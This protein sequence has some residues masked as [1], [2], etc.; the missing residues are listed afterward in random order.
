[1]NDI[2]TIKE[3]FLAIYD[4]IRHLT[5]DQLLHGPTETFTPHFK[6]LNALGAEEVDDE[7]A[8]KLRRDQELQTVIQ[9]ISHLKRLNG[10]RMEIEST[11]AIINS[12]DPWDELERFIYYPN[13]LELARME[14]NGAGLEPD[15]HVVFLGSGP[16][17]LSL[18]SLCKKYGITGTGI[19]KFQEYADLSQRLIKAL[20]LDQHINI[21]HGDHFTLPLSTGCSLI[22]VGADA[23]PKDEIFAHIAAKLPEGT[24]VSYRIYE[25]GLRRLMDI[26]STIEL[27][28]GLREYARVRPKPP[29]NNTSVFVIRTSESQ[30]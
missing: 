2:Q 19:E 27:P 1:M 18:I 17:P 28:P 12:H 15:D 16:L 13:Y 23:L 30:I 24:R 7:T 25:K 11:K 10:L 29:V 4:S 3:E 5:D 8:E 6:R 14:Y 21:I 20:K 26:H 9:H 22:M